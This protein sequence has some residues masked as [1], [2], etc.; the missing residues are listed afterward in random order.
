M[1]SAANYNS[2]KLLGQSGLSV[3]GEAA[4]PFALQ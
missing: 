2:Y 1:N 4:A 3:T